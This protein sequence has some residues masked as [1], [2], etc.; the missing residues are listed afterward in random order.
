MKTGE[1]ICPDCGQELCVCEDDRLSHETPSMCP[2]LDL[3][4]IETLAAKLDATDLW[5]SR[6]NQCTEGA[7]VLRAL[8][9]RL[10]EAEKD[11]A[12]WRA[13]E[14]ASS[15]VTLRL[16]NSRPDGRK[17]VIDAAIDAMKE[18]P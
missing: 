13:T 11:A 4:K 3:D 12:R 9:R 5:P 10:R 18:K 15:V 2:S 6:G 7:A 14:T 17:Q 1:F 16:H 8:I